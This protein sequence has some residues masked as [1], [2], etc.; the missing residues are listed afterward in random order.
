MGRF[1]NN[2]KDHVYAQ[3]EPCLL[4]SLCGQRKQH[5]VAL[6]IIFHSLLQKIF[7]FTFEAQSLKY[8]RLQ[9]QHYCLC[10][11]YGFVRKI[12]QHLELQSLTGSTLWMA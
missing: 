6:K 8:F 3:V 4:D 1:S 10:V 12:D 9:K 7:A 2:Q 5:A 11:R